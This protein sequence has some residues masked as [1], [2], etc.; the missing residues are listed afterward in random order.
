M[1][2]YYHR[3]H[4]SLQRLKKIKPEAD[5]R[6]QHGI[7]ANTKGFDINY[8]FKVEKQ[9]AYSNAFIFVIFEAP[10]LDII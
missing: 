7:C 5:F 6:S 10:L 8:F 3:Y 2:P 4:F 1:Y 9:V